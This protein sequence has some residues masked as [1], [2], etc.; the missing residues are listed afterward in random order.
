MTRTG[1]VPWARRVFGRF[2]VV[3]QVA[4]FVQRAQLRP[5]AFSFAGLGLL[6]AA[7]W[8][9]LGYGWGLAATGVSCLLVE[10]RLAH[11]E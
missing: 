10:W 5:V 9:G 11:R 2:A 8:I 4:A 6:S 1:R 7:A 3:W